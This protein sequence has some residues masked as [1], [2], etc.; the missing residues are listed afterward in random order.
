[1]ITNDARAA[2]LLA[3]DV[4]FIDLV[5]TADIARPRTNA[6]LSV[7]ET[8][9]LRLIY[10]A[11]DQSRD[12]PTPYVTGPNGETLDRNPLKDRRVREA[13]SI[14]INRPAI[15]ARVMEGAAI[16]TGQFLPPGSFSYVPDLGAP[17]YD[18]ERARELLAEAGYPGGFRIT[19]HGSNDRYLNDFEDCAGDWPDVDA[20]RRAD[21][22]GDPAL[23]EL[24]QAAPRH[25]GHD[26]AHVHRPARDRTRWTAPISPEADQAE[27]ARESTGA[28]GSNTC[29]S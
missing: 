13:L 12:G 29:S 2:A 27:R 28:C 5:P 22:G 24:L 19:L 21:G 4:Q 17:V 10:L 18:P 23:D 1:M 25:P 20:H 26:D 6:A 14:A 15:V 11:L 9:G 7:A 3:G 8:V 16:P